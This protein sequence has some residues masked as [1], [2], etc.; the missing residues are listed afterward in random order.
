MQHVGIPMTQLLYTL[1]L[2]IVYISGS[3]ALVFFFANLFL[4]LFMLMSSRTFKMN[5]ISRMC[6][7][8]KVACALICIYMYLLVPFILFIYN[9]QSAFVFS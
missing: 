4:T 9:K 6:K 3:L 2:L 7:T 5:L 1:E 8:L